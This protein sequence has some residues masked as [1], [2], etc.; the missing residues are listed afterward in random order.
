MTVS[1]FSTDSTIVRPPPPE[2][3]PHSGAASSSSRCGPAAIVASLHGR[4][5][6][7]LLAR[8]LAEYFLLTGTRPL[9]FDTDTAECTLYSWFRD[10]TVVIDVALVRDQMTLFDTMAQSAPQARV[11]DVSHHV[12]RR[13]FRVMQDSR[14]GQEARMCGVEPLIFYILDRD[15]D[16]YATA[17]ALHARFEDCGLILVDNAFVGRAKEKTRQSAAYRTLAGHDRTLALPL[18]SRDIVDVIEDGEVS[19]GA[20]MTRPLSRDDGGKLVDGLDFEQRVEL[21]GWLLKVFRE[22]SRVIRPQQTQ[23]PALAPAEAPG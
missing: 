20:I 16:A 7:S 11:V 1:G 13:F 9:L 22:I 21:R 6:K 8:V 3:R 23:A 4:T 19:L 5:G 14:F 17:L 2:S 10:D 12:F 15:P 18:L